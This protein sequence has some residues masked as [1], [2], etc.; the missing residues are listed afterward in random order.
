MTSSA[1]IQSATSSGATA[2]PSRFAGSAFFFNDCA[3][4]GAGVPVTQMLAAQMAELDI[5]SRR[6]PDDSIEHA[7]D[8]AREFMR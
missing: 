1:V 7:I 4:Y 2:L 3:A 8:A 6:E 5:A